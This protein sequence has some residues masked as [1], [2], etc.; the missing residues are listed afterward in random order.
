[1]SEFLSL[2]IAGIVTGSVYAVTATGLVVTYST[3]GIFNFAQGAIGMFL[4]Y[5]FWQLWQAWHLPTLLSLA[6]CLLV[7]APLAGLLIERFIMRSLYRASTAVSLVVTLG[8]MLLLVGVARE[9]LAPDP[10]LFDAGVLLRGPGDDQRH[11][12]LL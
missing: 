7:V 8:L 2:L 5:L 12:H 9:P 1:M 4:A 3:T 10:E 6:I 11:R